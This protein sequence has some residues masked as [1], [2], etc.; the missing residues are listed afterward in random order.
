MGERRTWRCVLA[1]CTSLLISLLAIGFVTSALVQ[2]AP[3]FGADERW[4]DA[5][6]SNES[7]DRLY[8]E[9]AGPGVLAGYYTFLRNAVSGDLGSSTTLHRPVLELIQ[10]RYLTTAKILGYGWLIGWAHALL[11][12]A[13]GV[14]LQS[15]IVAAPG[16]LAGAAVLC[17]PSALLAYL[18]YL[19][20]APAFLVVG[21]IIFARVYRLLDNLF[22]ATQAEPFVLAARSQGLPEF[23]IFLSQTV[24]A[25]LG[26][27]VALGGASVSIAMGATIAAEALCDQPGLG[28]LA[29]KAA[30]G[31]DL[32]LLL[33]LTLLIGAV[34]LVCNRAADVFVQ[35]RRASA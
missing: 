6:L 35:L 10:Q 2:L 16:T 27:I 25:T 4:L 26:E 18:C 17:I 22:R 12:A 11:L 1:G 29:W 33:S 24:P 21:L 23:R 5:R 13:V 34:T 15:R 3:G 9:A 14:I 19:A 8:D 30:L 31:R 20:R 32:P 7:I 28:H